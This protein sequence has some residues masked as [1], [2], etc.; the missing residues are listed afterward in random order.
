M[1]SKNYIHYSAEDF[2][3]DSCFQKWILEDDHMT[4]LFWEK[5]L[6][7][8]PAKSAEVDLAKR[9][10][11]QLNFRQYEASSEDFNEVWKNIKQIQNSE[12]SSTNFYTRKWLVGSSVAVVLLVISVILFNQHERFSKNYPKS[13]NQTL[14]DS[15][16][17]PGT[18]KA[19]L[20]LSNGS[21]I[22]LEKGKVYTSKNVRSNG[23]EIVYDN[24]LESD[25]IAYNHLTIPKGGQFFVKL[26][27]GTKVWLN[28]ETQLKYPVNFSK[29]AIREVELIY[30]E[31]Y[32]DVSPDT[33]EST[34]FKVIN[35]SQEVEVL[36][37]EFNIKA[38]LDESNIYTTLIEGKVTVSTLG[39][40]ELL[41][42]NQQ[43]NLDLK[44]NYTT[45]SEVNVYQEVSWKN[46]VF[47]FRNKSL[48]DI[49]KTLSRWY[50]VEVHFENETLEMKGF[51]G[52]LKRK[53]SI[54]EAL[55]TITATNGIEYEIKN[56]VILLK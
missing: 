28:S 45:T 29:G 32:F 14:T 38:Y 34:K 51:N 9:I 27:D 49:M 36:G 40:M 37:T 31:A 10:I 13:S 15:F 4:N 7:D 47:S 52:T 21:N 18:D 5:W 17:E 41:R 54:I 6:T 48:K 30:G 50:E 19:V 12:L 1:T 42:P 22:N 24:D 53:L 23:S 8:N 55:E 46:G 3:A 11:D 44:N 26:S 16:I 20:T 35:R 39:K 43:L 25:E 2:V 33:H 56:D